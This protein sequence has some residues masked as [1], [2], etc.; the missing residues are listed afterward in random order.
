MLLW[1]I[2]LRRVVM[3]STLAKD[4]SWAP[5]LAS[6]T[7]CCTKSLLSDSSFN[8]T[9]WLLLLLTE[10]EVSMCHSYS[11]REDEPGYKS[12]GEAGRAGASGSQWGHC[13][14]VPEQE[15]Q[16]GSG[17]SNQ[18]HPRVQII[19]HIHSDKARLR[20][21]QEVKAVGWGPVQI[22]EVHSQAW[23]W[24]QQQ[25]Q[26]LELKCCSCWGWQALACQSFFSH[27]SFYTALWFKAAE[28][29]HWGWPWAQA[30]KPLGAQG[31]GTENCNGKVT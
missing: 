9:T 2:V 16:S 14:T 17:E 25:R 5:P 18:G 3:C 31:P 20:S 13:P 12:H 4:F 22:S 27:S 29:H 26:G 30:V 11:V 15:K 10:N 1:F 28:L 7:M 8:S 19:R 21:S 6:G 23:P 24:Q